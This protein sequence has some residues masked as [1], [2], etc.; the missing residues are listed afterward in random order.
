M[1]DPDTMKGDTMSGRTVRAAGWLSAAILAVTVACSGQ[2]GGS[3]LWGGSPVPSAL[4]TELPVIPDGV[5]GRAIT[6]ENRTGEVGAGGQA[7]SNLGVGRKGS[8]CIPKVANGET[9]T[10][11]DIEG[12]GVIRHIWITIPDRSPQAMRNMILRMYWDNSP[13]PSVEVPLGDFFGVAHGQCRVLT[14]AYVTQVLGRGFNCY[15]PMPFAKHAKLTVTNDMPDGRDMGAFFYQI[16]YE[17]REALPENTGRF[18]AQFRR[19]N[20]TVEKEDYVLLD[21]VEGPGMFIGCVIGVRSLGPHWWGEGEMKFYMDGDT[22]FPTI[23]GTGTEDYFEAA[24]GME[25]YQT[26]YAGCPMCMTSDDFKYPLVSLYRWHEKDPV[27]FRKSLKATIQQIGYHK[28]LFERSDD[29]C[30]VAYWYQLEPVKQM[31]PLPDR[32]AR[33]AELVPPAKPKAAAPK[34][35]QDGFLSLFNGKDLSGWK[36][37]KHD[38]TEVAPADSAWSVEDGV[39]HC[40]GDESKD[41]WLASGKKYANFVLRLDYKISEGANSGIFL[42]VP[43]QERPAYTGFEVQIIDD[44]G[45]PASTHSSGSIYDLFAPVENVSRPVG[46]W[47]HVEITVNGLKC[48]VVL[49]GLQVIDAEFSLMTEPMGKYDFA[50]ANMPKTGFIGLQNHGKGTWFKDIRIKELR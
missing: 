35:G 36:I 23:C 13:V 8:P 22:D 31:P 17:L 9:A 14:T 49:N 42:R 7:A 44:I 47:N 21:N 41:Y 11:M 1:T 4:N 16:D 3:G 20:P 6:W 29:W 18:H 24:W 32:A 48:R 39:I 43:G 19:Q 5:V 40:T 26:P 25:E 33:M 27:Y 12:C 46:E 34:A 50:Y 15:F 28:G 10:L 2:Q 37:Y 45:Q 38:G 30:S